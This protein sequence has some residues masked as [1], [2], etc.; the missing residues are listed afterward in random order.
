MRRIAIVCCAAAA[1]LGAQ[2]PER[3]G[4]VTEPGRTLARPLDLVLGGPTT[5]ALERTVFVLVDPSPELVDAGFADAFADAV[6]KN[7]VSMAKLRLGLGVVGHD[8]TVVVSPTDNHDAVVDAVRACLQKPSSGFQNVYESVRSLASAL[9]R[10]PGDRSIL[11][12]S[13]ENGDL[14]DDV[15]KTVLTLRKAKVTMEILASETTLSDSYWAARPHHQP[16]SG[17]ELRGGDGAVG[18]LPWGFLF[19][20]YAANE[21]SPSGYAMWGLTRLAAASEGRVFLHASGKQTAHKCSFD[22]QCLFCGDDHQPEDR[23]WNSALMAQLG[24]LSASRSDTYRALGADPVFRELIKVWRSAAKAGLVA[25]EP[26]VKVSTRAASPGRARGGKQLRLLAGTN[27][28][29]NAKRA[30]Q[31][32]KQAAELRDKLQKALADTPA[33]ESMPRSVAAAKYTVVLLQLTRVNLLA[34]AGWAREFAPRWFD[35]RTDDPLPPELLPVDRE[36]KPTGVFYFN[37]S[38]CHGVRPF[39]DVELPGKE[40]MRKD[41]QLLDALFTGFQLRYGKSQFGEALRRNGIARFY[42]VYPAATGP[43]PRR[44]PKSKPAPK[45]PTT[46]K[47]PTRR[48]TGSGPTGGPTTGGGG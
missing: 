10:Q 9:Y 42:P 40:L 14:E 34:F 37:L 7:A 25:S 15:E 29:R 19:Q 28:A 17:T 31:A 44:R 33:E 16:P 5:E 38:L 3:A 4:R 45:G 2:S 24:P 20:R 18:D 23:N 12:V 11:L 8:G 32:A 41:L 21:Q 27:F 47:R 35:P 6:N 48:G 30:E 43:A 13:L 26:A 1:L 36:R 46:P 22:G 39:Y